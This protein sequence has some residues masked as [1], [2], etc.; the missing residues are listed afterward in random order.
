[1]FSRSRC[2]FC[3]PSRRWRIGSAHA[4]SPSDPESPIPRLLPRLGYLRAIMLP[5]RPRDTLSPRLPRANLI[6]QADGAHHW[7]QPCRQS[8]SRGGGRQSGRRSGRLL[9]SATQSATIPS[10]SLMAILRGLTR[11]DRGLDHIA[12]DAPFLLAALR[13]GSDWKL[14]LLTRAPVAP[15]A[16]LYLLGCQAKARDVRRRDR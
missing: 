9:E 16:R 5:T 3:R 14:E 12:D 4:P 15:D 2:S 8:G 13:F 1:M 10:C 11:S 6:L 7:H